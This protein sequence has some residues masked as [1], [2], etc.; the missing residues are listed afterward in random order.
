[1]HR[2]RSQGASRRGEGE[3]VLNTTWIGSDISPYAVIVKALASARTASPL[4]P[5]PGTPRRDAADR[6]TVAPLMEGTTPPHP[7]TPRQRLHGCQG[8]KHL[9]PTLRGVCRVI[10]SNTTAL[11]HESMRDAELLTSE[12]VCAIGIISVISAL[13]SLAQLASLASLASLA[14]NELQRFG[15][16]GRRRRPTI[17]DERCLRG[18]PCGDWVRGARRTGSPSLGR[19]VRRGPGRIALG[20]RAGS[21]VD[22]VRAITV[23]DVDLLIVIRRRARS[24]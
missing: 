22:R 6:C 20:G 17:W 19:L 11:V 24:P 15:S 10:P 9:P 7:L 5:C 3:A 12:G 23:D 13:A 4:R 16:G 18:A 14:R 1:M 21:H 8:T 2:P